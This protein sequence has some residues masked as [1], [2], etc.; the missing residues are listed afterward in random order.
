MELMLNYIRTG[1]ELYPKEEYQLS[2]LQNELKSW[3]LEPIKTTALKIDDPGLSMI[4]HKP[5]SKQPDDLSMA[6]EDLDSKLVGIHEQI[7]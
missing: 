3:N 4:E 5:T 7:E 1:K 2:L 6:V